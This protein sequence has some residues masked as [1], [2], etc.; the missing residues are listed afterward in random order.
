M[1][2]TPMI[3]YS[4][5][6]DFDLNLQTIDDLHKPALDGI[7]YQD[8]IQEQMAGETS[9]YNNGPT[10]N[11][12]NHL[13]ANKTLAWID[14]MT[15][16]NRTYGDFAAGE[17]LDFMVLNRRYDVKNSQIKDLTTIS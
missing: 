9:V 8:L 11:N 16:Y 3:D 5:G 4:Q 2:I 6:N 14:Y 13:S 15:N 10:I 12:L 17:P 7:G 1:A